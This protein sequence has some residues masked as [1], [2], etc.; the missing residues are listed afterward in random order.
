MRRIY[1][2]YNASTPIAPEVSAAMQP[3]LSGFYGNPSGS[4]WGSLEAKLA[5]AQ[6]REQVASFLKCSA[7]EIVF[8]SGGTEA[9]NLAIKGVFFAQRGGPFHIITSAVEHPAT[10]EPCRFLQSLGAELT[11]LPVDPHGSVDPSALRDALRPTTRLVSIMH[12][13]NEVGTIQPIEEIGRIVGETD[14]LFHVDAAQSA[15]KLPLNVKTLGVDLL[16]ITGQ[17]IYGPKGVGA[18]YVRAGTE[19][20]PL[21]HGPSQQAGL[22]AGTESALLD[23][24][25]GLACEIAGD[26]LETEAA[27]LS[28]LRDNFHRGLCDIFGDWIRLNGHPASRLPNTLNV[29]LLHRDGSEILAALEG[30]AASTGSACHTDKAELSPTLAA[31]GVP[32]NWGRGAIRFSLGRQTT[33]SDIDHVLGQL[34]RLASRRQPVRRRPS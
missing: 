2:D 30:V 34:M 28:A 6:A 22:R 14:A 13:N 7:R 29:S 3:F 9:N 5:I 23:V 25:L 1:L 31:M 17:K 12:A 27:R 26:R 20:V 21:I 4:N 24:A 8:T 10:L 19:I 16:S 18:L 11:V 15:G 33:S 32:E